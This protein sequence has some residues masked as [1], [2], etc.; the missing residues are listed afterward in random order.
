MKA[1][2]QEIASQFALEGAITAIDSLGEGFINDTFI[3]RTAGDAPDYILQR[4]NKSIFPDVP[5]MMENIRKVT[6]HIR[7]RVAAEGG[8]PKRE[9]MTVVPTLDGRLCHLDPQGEYWADFDAGIVRAEAEARQKP[10]QADEHPEH[11][12]AEIQRA[13]R[14]QTRRAEQGKRQILPAGAVDLG[15]RGVLFQTHRGQRE[16]EHHQNAEGDDRDAAAAGKLRRAE[17]VSGNGGQDRGVQNADQ[18]ELS[19][20]KQSSP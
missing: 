13:A 11:R 1:E 9:A 18:A 6:E 12:A 8:D 3:V 10:E 2:L 20:H 14:D 16:D 4:K 7:R 5:A 17:K 19:F 15:I